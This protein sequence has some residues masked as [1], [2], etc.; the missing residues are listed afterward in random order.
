MEA[1]API[2]GFA[3]TCFVSVANFSPVPGFITLW[4]SK[5]LN[6]V[7]HSF[8]ILCAVNNLLWL[9]MG[10]ASETF[11]IIRVNVIA[12]SFNTLYLLIFHT[13]KGD[14]LLFL[15]V[16]SVAMV[17]TLYS[18]VT[19]MSVE[20]ITLMAGVNNTLTMLAPLEQLKHVFHTKDSKYIDIYIMTLTLPC[21]FCW[22]MFGV[23]LKIWAMIVPNLIGTLSCS[24]LIVLFL[25]YR[26]PQQTDEGTE[27]TDV[28]EE[29]EKDA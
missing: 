1:Y 22:L 29:V 11:D 6:L 19:Y 24:V 2:F 28:A 7:S 21:S 14:L 5:N 27:L 25:A 9:S 18:L 3:G 26:K 16:Y 12:F 23:C 13:V 10:L 8:F 4:K 20:H 15:C 17:T